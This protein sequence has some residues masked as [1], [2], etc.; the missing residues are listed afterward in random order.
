M[1]PAVRAALMDR[2]RMP[3]VLDL[4]PQVRGRRVTMT[5]VEDIDDYP[6]SIAEL[7]VFGR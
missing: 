7:A 6:W 2:Q 4:S 3:I 5:L 1:G